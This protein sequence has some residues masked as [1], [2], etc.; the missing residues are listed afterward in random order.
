MKR[1]KRREG[2]RPKPH[3]R[4]LQKEYPKSTEIVKIKI[5]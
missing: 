4:A 5:V 2:M 3:F 1:K